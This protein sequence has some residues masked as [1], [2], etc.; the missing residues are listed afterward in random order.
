MLKVHP[1][2]FLGLITE[3]RD[4]AK[5]ARGIRSLNLDRFLDQPVYAGNCFS[6]APMAYGNREALGIVVIFLKLRAW[7]IGYYE[8]RHE[9]L[10]FQ[11]VCRQYISLRKLETIYHDSHDILIGSSSGSC[12]IATD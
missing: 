3:W 6:S 8:L 2:N 12:P 4:V 1:S 7:F 11:S 9:I 5:P 10:L